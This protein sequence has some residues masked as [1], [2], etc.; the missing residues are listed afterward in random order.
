M[1]FTKH[2]PHMLGVIRL[3]IGI[4]CIL[5]GGW[6]SLL[7]VAPHGYASFAWRGIGL[8]VLFGGIGLAC[9]PHLIKGSWKWTW[10][11]VALS[12]LPLCPVLIGFV[13]D[14]QRVAFFPHVW[15]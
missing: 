13:L 1:S 11:V 15:F 2:V 5:W 3:L 8:C 14:W 6:V 7:G 9:S 10:V 12:A 4:P